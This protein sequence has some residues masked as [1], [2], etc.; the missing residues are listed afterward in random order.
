MDTPAMSNS[1]ESF[2]APQA[3]ISPKTWQAYYDALASITFYGI[4]AN[5]NKSGF[6][7]FVEDEI[8]NGGL[9]LY[10]I[11]FNRDDVL[12]YANRIIKDLG[13]HPADVN[14][15][16]FDEKKIHDVVNALNDLGQDS[17]CVVKIIVNTFDQ[18]M[19]YEIDDFWNNR[20]NLNQ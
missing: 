2:F 16:T 4:M 20:H 13:F 19:I 10:R 15:V 17:G 11:F 3:Y 5:M 12:S 1:N 14:V 6:K 18:N 7:Y 8:G 9:G